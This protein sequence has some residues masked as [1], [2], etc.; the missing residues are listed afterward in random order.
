MLHKILGSRV[1]VFCTKCQLT[2]LQRHGI[3]EFSPRPG[4][5]RREQKKTAPKGCP[6]EKEENKI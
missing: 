5:P 6:Q 1:L 3:M 2:K 4:G